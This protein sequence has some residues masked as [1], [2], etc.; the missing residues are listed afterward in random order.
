MRLRRP[1]QRPHRRLHTRAFP[2]GSLAFP[3]S[4]FPISDVAALTSQ[5]AILAAQVSAIT[6]SPPRA[7]RPDPRRIHAPAPGRG[8]A[9]AHTPPSGPTSP[10]WSKSCKILVRPEYLCCNCGENNPC[11][12]MCDTCG[13]LGNTSCLRCK[14][15]LATCRLVDKVLDAAHIAE[16]TNAARSSSLRAYRAKLARQPHVGAIHRSRQ[17]RPT[18][19]QAAADASD[20]DIDD[21]MQFP[22]SYA[23]TV[24]NIPPADS[25]MWF[26][27]HNPVV[28]NAPP[29]RERF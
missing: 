14:K 11:N 5:V 18:R 9:S 19:S 22:P 21:W 28:N 23:V 27:V 12:K 8:H 26:D 13:I 29:T 1:L 16:L 15:S 6:S 3:R 2:Y 10:C 4:H 25:A 20:D 24:H 7:P 17:Q